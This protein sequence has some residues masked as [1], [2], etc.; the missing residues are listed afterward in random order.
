MGPRRKQDTFHNLSGAPNTD[1]TVPT[2]PPP[3]HYQ[4]SVGI[5]WVSFMLYY[6]LYIYYTGAI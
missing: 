4:N 1:S 6:L 5:G 3:N 2:P